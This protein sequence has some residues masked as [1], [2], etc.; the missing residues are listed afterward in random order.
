M[1]DDDDFRIITA[2]QAVFWTCAAIVLA[3]ILG[4]FS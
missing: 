3:A 4:V 2:D 1:N